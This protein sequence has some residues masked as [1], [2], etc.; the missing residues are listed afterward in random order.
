MGITGER[1]MPTYIVRKDDDTPVE[2]AET[3]EVICSYKELQEM[4]VEYGLKQILQ[5][6]SMVTDTKSVM[7]RAGSEWQ[8][9]LKT[10]KKN[11]GRGN[12][13]KV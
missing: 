6:P 4:C 9:V 5:A 3:W 11:S 8:D 2:E 7:T 10:V 13:I 1:I 12:T